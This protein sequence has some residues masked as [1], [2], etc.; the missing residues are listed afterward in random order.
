MSETF[1][2][3]KLETPASRTRTVRLPGGAELRKVDFASPSF[4][5]D[6]LQVFKK[7][8][9]LARREN[10]IAQS[11]LDD[12]AKNAEPLSPDWDAARVYTKQ[13]IA[14]M[15]SHGSGKKNK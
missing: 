4:G 3:T 8:V 6:L 2:T 12:F 11:V 5:Q 14:A 13:K 1:K 7:N 15:L 10:A 9:A